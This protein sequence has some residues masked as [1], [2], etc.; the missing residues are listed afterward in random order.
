MK[1]LLV[2]THTRRD[3]LP[4]LCSGY[5]LI[6]EW[7]LEAHSTRQ[8]QGICG[9]EFY[10]GVPVVAYYSAK[11]LAMRDMA[12]VLPRTLLCMVMDAGWRDGALATRLHV[13]LH[14]TYAAHAPDSPHLYQWPRIVVRKFRAYVSCPLQGAIIAIPRQVVRPPSRHLL[15]PL[16]HSLLCKEHRFV[17]VLIVVIMPSYCNTLLASACKRQQDGAP[18]Q[19]HGLSTPV[20]LHASLYFR[21][22]HRLSSHTLRNRCKDRG[23]NGP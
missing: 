12:V 1:P 19:E 23:G 11:R 9:A 10:P 5:L 17:I 3:C 21:V 22:L 6:D 4:C 18:L 7:S 14:Y 8:P 13:R 16:F 15:P 2:C 20:T